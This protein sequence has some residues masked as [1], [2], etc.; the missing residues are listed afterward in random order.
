[1]TKLCPKCNTVKPL[2]D[3]YARENGNKQTYCKL[4]FNTYCMNRWKQRKL[5]AIAYKGGCCMKCKG[6]FHQ[7]VY[8]FH[9]TGVKDVQWN[10]LRLRSWDK[11]KA[12]LDVCQLLCANCHRLEHWG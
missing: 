3:Y 10:K 5:D 11:I 9:H 8:E 1:M 12:E 4:C 2:S 6:T 7:T